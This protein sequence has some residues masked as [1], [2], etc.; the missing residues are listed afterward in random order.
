[1]T[2]LELDPTPKRISGSRKV[3]PPPPAPLLEM[4]P[5]WGLKAV[6]KQVTIILDQ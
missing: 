2:R 3:R 1:M 6:E 5:V 4:I